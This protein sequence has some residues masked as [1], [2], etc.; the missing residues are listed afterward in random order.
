MLREAG[1]ELVQIDPPFA[2]P[3]DPNR[4]AGGRGVHPPHGPDPA[5]V[6]LRLAVAKLGS[7]PSDL[8]RGSVILTADTVGAALSGR[9]IGTPETP[10]A[11]RATLGGLVGAE[12][13]IA[14]GVALRLP[15]GSRRRLRDTATV[16][17]GPVPPRVVDAYIDT[18]DWRG[19]A[20]GYN[21]AER[22]AAGWP[23]TVDG[24]PGTVMGLPMRRL[25][26]LLRCLLRGCIGSRGC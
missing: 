26:P 23:L 16:R 6:A 14:T 7:V 22:L 19:K 21:L 1:F 2:D 12:H 10:A 24:D 13:R 17:L 15:D 3:A 11:A 18:G 9:L 20:G 5:A 8:Y 4:E 25:G